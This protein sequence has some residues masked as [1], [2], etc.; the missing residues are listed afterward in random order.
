MFSLLISGI[1][2]VLTHSSLFSPSDLGS[3][4]QKAQKNERT[5]SRLALLLA[6]AVS[7][8]PSHSK[9]KFYGAGHFVDSSSLYDSKRAYSSI[10]VCSRSIL[11][12]IVDFNK[13]PTDIFLHTWAFD[14]EHEF[15]GLYDLTA[16]RFEDNRIAEREL[17]PLFDLASASWGEI[18]FTLSAMRVVRLMLDHERQAGAKLYDRVVVSRADV[19]L[20]IDLDLSKLSPAKAVLFSNTHGKGAGDFHWVMTHEHAEV[21]AHAIAS[22][23]WVDEEVAEATEAAA[24]AAAAAGIGGGE[25]QTS[26]AP[27]VRMQAPLSSSSLQGTK[28][29]C[30]S[31]V[32]VGQ[33]THQA[34]M[35]ASDASGT[36]S[37]LAGGRCNVVGNHGNM[38]RFAKER[39]DAEVR[40]D[41]QVYAGS[42]QD[43]Y[44]KV[45]WHLM[46]CGPS[47]DWW[48]QHM[49]AEYSMKESDW[50]AIESLHEV[51]KCTPQEP[52]L[53]LNICCREGACAKITTRTDNTCGKRQGRH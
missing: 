19:F 49:A 47:R 22:V 28:I 51:R 7:R 52:V 30:S 42:D 46:V 8:L 18:S 11:K 6:G 36:A 14:L 44:R 2:I 53:I 13:V 21:L 50:A 12:H 48:R 4:V 31:G 15:R 23:V 33:L 1:L 3:S 20:A 32:A 45:P 25:A 26:E 17:G 38:K 10:R 24:A 34:N 35:S 16:A 40:S 5:P 39:L 9:D 43:V 37:R 29:Y 41:N 27:F